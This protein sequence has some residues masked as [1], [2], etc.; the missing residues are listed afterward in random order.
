METKIRLELADAI[1]KEKTRLNKVI[2]KI[3]QRTERMEIMSITSKI[4]DLEMY[5]RSLVDVTP[6]SEI[7][8][9]GLNTVKS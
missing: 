6:I 7:K 3:E 5:I 2:P 4:D 9:K 8:P 1:K